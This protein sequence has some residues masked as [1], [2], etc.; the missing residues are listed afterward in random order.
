MKDHPDPQ[1]KLRALVSGL[2]PDVR[3]RCWLTMLQ[4]FI[5]DSGSEPTGQVFVLAGLISTVNRWI[6]FVPKWD[7]VL[8]KDRAIKYFKAS[9][10]HNRTGE[11]E[12]GW[13][14]P[15]IDQRVME[16]AD[17]AAAH[18][19]YRIH[20]VMHWTAFNAY[21]RDIGDSLKQPYAIGFS[22]PYMVLFFT[23]VLAINSYRKAVGLDCECEYIFDEQGKVGKFAATVYEIL[24]NSP[25]LRDRLDSLPKFD[26]DKRV[27]PLQAADL[28]AWNVHDAAIS[29]EGHDKYAHLKRGLGQLPRIEILIDEKYLVGM[30]KTLLE[31]ARTA[32]QYLKKPI[33][34]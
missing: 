34:I 8:K 7:A 32:P 17:I 19:Q 27:L 18:A 13:T 14:R 33:P 4:A 1:A 2:R 23:A 26:S 3:E 29:E 24:Q 6:E 16:L 20:C 11:F 9:E 30:R 12:H 28:Y 15:L 21:L 22:N 5:D 10:A 31:S 25:S